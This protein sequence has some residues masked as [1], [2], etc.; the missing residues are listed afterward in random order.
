MFLFFARLEF[1][2]ALVFKLY[3]TLN[4]PYTGVTN[5]N[6]LASSILAGLKNADQKRVVLNV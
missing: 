2:T 5:C 6:Y 3:F 4:P 1:I